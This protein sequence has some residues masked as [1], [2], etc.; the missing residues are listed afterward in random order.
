MRPECLQKL[1]WPT[2]NI[3][4]DCC[5]QPWD[6]WPSARLSPSSQPSIGPPTVVTGSLYTSKV[7]VGLRYFVVKVD[8]SDY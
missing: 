1:E 2:G 4:I 6:P 3:S 7:L 8:F 5:A